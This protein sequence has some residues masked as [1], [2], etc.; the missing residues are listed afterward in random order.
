MVNVLDLIADRNS[1]AQFLED[2]NE[3][4]EQFLQQKSAIEWILDTKGFLE[5]RA[6]WIREEQACSD[7]MRT[8]KRDDIKS[9]QAEWQLA[10]RFLN[11]IDNILAPLPNVDKDLDFTTNY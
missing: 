2:K 7:R 6:Y 1:K 3:A 10:T 9:V 4:R 11:F 5:I 8:A